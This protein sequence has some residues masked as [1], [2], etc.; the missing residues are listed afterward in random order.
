M[1]GCSIE[2]LKAHLE[3]Q[4]Q[5]GMTWENYGYWGWH[6]DHAHPIAAHDLTDPDQQRVAF[7]FTN[8]QPLWRE[9]NQKKSARLDWK[10]E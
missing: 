8:L 9:D 10:P 2:E 7:H 3:A 1:I 5:P 4:F 6:V